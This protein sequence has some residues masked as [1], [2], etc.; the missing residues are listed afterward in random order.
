TSNLSVIIKNLQNAGY[1][2]KEPQL[3][4]SYDFGLHQNRDRVFIVGIRKDLSY[5]FEDFEYPKPINKK[6]FLKNLIDGV[7]KDSV[8]DKKIFDPKDIFGHKIP[9]SRNRFQKLNELNDFFIFCDTR[10]GHTTIHS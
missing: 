2:V 5:Y 6:S 1:V 4:N 8:I 10:N 7:D 3:L 9:M